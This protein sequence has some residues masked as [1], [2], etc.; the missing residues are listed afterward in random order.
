MNDIQI[1]NGNK[2]FFFVSY[3]HRDSDKIHPYLKGLQ[4]SGY[5][6]W[7]DKGIEAGTE[8]SNNIADHLKRC[9]AF[10]FF[11]SKNSVK[12]ENCLDEVAY[13]KSHNK[14]S[15]LVFL[16]D[17]ADLPVG[18]EMQTARFQRMFLTRQESVGHFVDNFSQASM[19]D[20]CRN[21]DAAPLNPE[22]YKVLKKTNNTKSKKAPANKKALAIGIA[23]G[24]VVVALVITIILLIIKG[25]SNNNTYD[26]LPSEN[27]GGTETNTAAEQT[28]EKEPDVIELSDSLSDCT[29]RMNGIVYQLPVSFSALQKDGWTLD[30]GDISADTYIGGHEEYETSLIN[31]GNYI[32]V[33]FYNDS[34]NAKQIRD[35]MIGEITASKD[36]ISDF[37]IAG[38]VTFDSTIDD[39]TAKVGTP[40]YKN[41]DIDDCVVLKWNFSETKNV[42]IF[43]YNDTPEYNFIRFS[44]FVYPDVYFEPEET[45][46]EYL[47]KYQQ[48]SALGDDKIRNKCSGN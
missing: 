7:F 9:S 12:S 24:V 35:C 29:F 3:A 21:Q 26:E 36:D 33:V 43:I 20:I 47:N 10:L 31:N 38:G 48:P 2:P 5:N 39:I 17:D 22:A 15:L 44:N 45:P 11:V 1:Y 34:E 27:T 4:D 32:D 25:A 46:P 6:I 19:F 8:W 40:S 30:A 37:C 18:T 41:D 28:T 23:V 16:D 14:P 42:E 13:A